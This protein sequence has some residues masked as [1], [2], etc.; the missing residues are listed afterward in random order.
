MIVYKLTC[1]CVYSEVDFSNTSDG[2]EPRVSGFKVVVNEVTV[3]AALQDSQL[4]QFAVLLVEFSG[5]LC[6]LSKRIEFSREYDCFRHLLH[7]L[8][9][10]FVREH[11]RVVLDGVVII[12]PELS[13]HLVRGALGFLNR[14]KVR[15]ILLPVHVVDHGE[16]GHVE[17]DEMSFVEV[18]QENSAT[19]RDPTTSTLPEGADV[20]NLD[21]EFLSVSYDP[22]DSS[23]RVVDGSWSF[24]LGSKSVANIHNHRTSLNCV[25][26]ADRLVLLGCASHSTSSVEVNHAVTSAVCMD[27][28]ARLLNFDMDE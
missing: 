16:H 23:I 26:C 3:V 25:P 14:G 22:L 11:E 2:S 4:Q 20:V 8:S 13:E 9:A 21:I 6:W 24:M 18:S 19:S 17:L 12:E 7:L 5:F 27:E 10:S 28:C 1:I 15:L